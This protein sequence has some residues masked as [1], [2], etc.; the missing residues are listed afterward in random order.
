VP[1]AARGAGLERV[2]Q[3][4]GV[5][6]GDLELPGYEHGTPAPPGASVVEQ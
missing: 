4:T 5:A 2:V 6:A 3:A 1:E